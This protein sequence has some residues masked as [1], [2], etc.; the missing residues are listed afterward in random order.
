MQSICDWVPEQI[1]FDLEAV[2][3]EK[4]ASDTLRDRALLGIPWGEVPVDFAAW[5]EVFLENSWH[6]FDT[7]HTI[8][9]CGWVL[10]ARGLKRH[11][12]RLTQ[13][14]KISGAVPGTEADAQ[15]T[16]SNGQPSLPRSCLTPLM[17]DENFD[18]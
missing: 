3:P 11:L 17:A 12:Q 9:R 10:I 18:A 1:R 16:C 13:S 5:L 8:S 7:R 15:T 14:L 6:I 2:T 4:I